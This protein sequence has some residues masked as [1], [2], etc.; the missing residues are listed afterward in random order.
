MVQAKVLFSVIVLTI[1]PVVS[2]ERT[3]NLHHHPLKPADLNE[4]RVLHA[5]REPGNWMTYGRTYDEQ[6][7]SP[8]NQVNDHK[9]RK[10][11]V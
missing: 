6:R 9:D 11:V 4:F 8:L 7:F 10:S 5:D 2:S 3:V 1:I